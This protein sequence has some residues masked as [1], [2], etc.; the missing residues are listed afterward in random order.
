[1]TVQIKPYLVE[2][3]KHLALSKGSEFYKIVKLALHDAKF[4]AFRA[5]SLDRTSPTP[6]AFF[7]DLYCYAQFKRGTMVQNGPTV[8]MS[9]VCQEELEAVSRG[10]PISAMNDAVND[11]VTR[12]LGYLKWI[13]N[14]RPWYS[15]SELLSWAF[16]NTELLDFPIS[17]VRAPYPKFIIELQHLAPYSVEFK[18]TSRLFT[19]GFVTV[20][21]FDVEHMRIGVNG[22]LF[23]LESF[24][25]DDPRLSKQ[26]QIGLIPDK[27]EGQM[28][29]D[30]IEPNL[31]PVQRAAFLFSVNV[32]LYV[33]SKDSDDV[34]CATSLPYLQ[35]ERKIQKAKGS[36]K[37]RYQTRLK[38]IPPNYVHVLGSKTIIDR[39]KVVDSEEGLSSRPASPRKGHFVCGHWRHYR[40]GEGR[41][42]SVLRY[43]QPFWRGAPP[44]EEQS[45]ETR[46]YMLK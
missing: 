32:M 6:I 26:Y 27:D 40:V 7:L 44:T 9:E 8:N 37:Q 23:T 19:P 15:V 18:G 5:A 41:K 22:L 29:I 25:V 35:M 36:L 45:A 21:N 17:H 20:E 2:M 13:N 28:V 39:K 11:S 30:C 43:L 31:L 46:V 4:I 10:L 34:L 33:T 38:T 3:D 12:V 14:G 24:A 16:L 42:E 1:M